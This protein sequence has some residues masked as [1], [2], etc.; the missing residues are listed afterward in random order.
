MNTFKKIPQY[1]LDTLAIKFSGSNIFDAQ[2]KARMYGFFHQP[3]CMIETM[4]ETKIYFATAELDQQ[5]SSGMVIQN[6]SPSNFS[7]FKC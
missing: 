5:L 6:R 2:R 7:L 4:S 3:I 1:L